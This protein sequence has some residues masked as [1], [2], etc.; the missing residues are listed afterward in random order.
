MRNTVTFQAYPKA[1]IANL[2]SRAASLTESLPRPPG[3]EKSQLVSALSSSDA[4]TNNIGNVFTNGFPSD[5]VN[6]ALGSQFAGDDA[7]ANT[8]PIGTGANYGAAQCMKR[9]GI[10][11]Q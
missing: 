11:S 6:A 7:K 3:C 5:L 2:Q 10:K 4:G 9:C 8:V 1:G